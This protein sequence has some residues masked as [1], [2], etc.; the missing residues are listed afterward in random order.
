[1]R[2]VG[3]KWQRE[4][5]TQ[6]DKEIERWRYKVAEVIRHRTKERQRLNNTETPT[7]I[8]I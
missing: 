6:K 2:G 7:T 8:T 3:R 5:K 4:T 1:M